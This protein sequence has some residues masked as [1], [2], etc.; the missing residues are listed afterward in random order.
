MFLFGKQ[1]TPKEIL[2]ENQRALNKSMR[3]IDRER[4]NLQNQE[5]KIILDIKKMAKQG[6]MNSAK[7]MAKDLVRTRYHIQKFY[8]MKT[9]LQ[10]VSLRIQTLQST[11]QMAEAMK[12]VTK[13]MMTMNRQMNLPQFTKIMMEFEIQSDKMDMK[14]EMMNDTMD[15]VMEQDD[16]EEQSQEILN[17]VLDEIGIDL[18]SQLVD[19]PTTVG[20]AVA[21]KHQ[22][23]G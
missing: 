20:T 5:K 1:K 14:E 6:Q 3:E 7:I 15:Q 8:E 13:A 9:Q 22:V 12:G 18:A 2:R 16:E 11:Q 17:Q 23:N 4:V 10:A 19:T 21:S